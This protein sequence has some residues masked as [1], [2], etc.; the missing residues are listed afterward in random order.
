MDELNKWVHEEIEV[1]LASIERGNY[2]AAKATL[3]DVADAVQT[4]ADRQ[5]RDDDQL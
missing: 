5:C 2:E 3:L 1:A 4:K